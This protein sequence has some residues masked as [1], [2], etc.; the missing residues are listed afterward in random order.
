[1]EVHRVAGGWL[2]VSPPPEI[3]NPRS[4]DIRSQSS[5][6]DRRRESRKL[7]NKKTTITIEEFAREHLAHFSPERKRLDEAIRKIIMR[8]IREGIQLEIDADDAERILESP[9][10]YG[11]LLKPY[12]ELSPSQKFRRDQKISLKHQSKKG[13]K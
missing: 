10:P 6:Y 11:K 2:Y 3:C 7:G 8:C 13:R 1:M 12:E 4:G 9:R 5:I